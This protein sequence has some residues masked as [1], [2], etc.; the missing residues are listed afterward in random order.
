MSEWK[1]IDT[2]PADGSRIWLSN[3]ER[4][5]LATAHKDGSLKLPSRHEC[6]F[7][8]PAN[9]PEPPKGVG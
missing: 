7:W 5:W 1:T 9:V 3:G 2:E 8:Q 6:K 4:V